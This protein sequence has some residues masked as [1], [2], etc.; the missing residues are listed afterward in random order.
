ML[1]ISASAC[2]VHIS[3]DPAPPPD[4]HYQPPQSA[5][6]LFKD[7][8][9][10]PVQLSEPVDQLRHHDVLHLSYPSS[11]LTGDPDNMVRGVFFRSRLPGAKKLVIVLPIWG[12]STYPP[13]R[14]SYGYA[15]H[16][17]GDAQIIWI[18]GDAPLFPWDGLSTTASLDEFLEMARNSAE[19][20]RTSV[21]D[22]RRLLDWAETRSD[23]DQSRIG[24]V[25]FS[26]SALVAATLMGNDARISS[27]VL[28]MG[29][30]ELG[31]VFASCGNR[32]GEVRRHVLENYGW[33]LGQYRDFFAKLFGPAD[34]VRYRGHYN[35]EK[36]LMIDASFDDCMP[37]AAR[38]ALWEA[39]GRPERI[40]LPYRHRGAFYS[41]TPLG[42]NFARRKIYRFLDK[43]LEPSSPS[44]RQEKGSAS[45][46]RKSAAGS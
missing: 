13:S 37:R 20:Y 21:V 15:K 14:I 23:V 45:Q 24:I 33:S 39:T 4:Y 12:T 28:M 6:P 9:A 30:A 3:R 2:V 46:A 8:I 34:P 41:I 36:I 27:A 17:R 22:L 10:G 11:G 26:M 29:A 44:N 38:D 7:E 35:P 43:A 40:S 32:A 5:D 1:A 42:L 16:S 19:R 31:D 25:G 18:L